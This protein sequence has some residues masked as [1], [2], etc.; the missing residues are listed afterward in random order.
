MW[1]LVSGQRERTETVSNQ[2]ETD[3]DKS[4]VVS[5]WEDG[6]T[7]AIQV[8]IGSYRL[9]GPKFNGTSERLAVRKLTADDAAELRR[10]LDIAF[11]QVTA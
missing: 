9:A 1:C 10:Q 2:Q 6:V 4:M 7:G 3:S 8:V 5:A 11:P